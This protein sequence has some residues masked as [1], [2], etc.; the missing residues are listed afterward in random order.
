M[1]HTWRLDVSLS[2]TWFS[3]NPSTWHSGP[4]RNISAVLTVPYWWPKPHLCSRRTTPL[5]TSASNP[6]YL[7][8]IHRMFHWCT[9]DKYFWS[10]YTVAVAGTVPHTAC[11]PP[12]SQAWRTSQCW[13]MAALQT[14]GTSKGLAKHPKWY[15]VHPFHAK[16]VLSRIV[17]FQLPISTNQQMI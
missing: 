8:G 12:K 3:F 4:S 1:I 11:C 2:C 10:A 15:H 7:P 6:K 9:A 5:G 14:N 16:A 13:S 17:W